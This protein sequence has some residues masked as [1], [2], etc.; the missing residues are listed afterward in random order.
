MYAD[1]TNVGTINALFSHIIPGFSPV[2]WL[3]SAGFVNV[4]LFSAQI[5]ASMGFAVVV[6][7][8]ALKAIPGELNEAARM[9]GANELHIFRYITVPLIWPTVTVIITLT[10]IG[11]LKFFDFVWPMTGG[12][13]AGASEVIGTRM[14]IEAFQSNDKGVGSAIAVVL[15]VAVIP[16]MAINI[17]R[18]SAEGPR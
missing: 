17:R 15:L 8:A 5:W 9:D 1:D 11:L 14:Y 7:S 16:I 3:G 18:F 12:G 13:P 4:A 2:S 10:M 6:L